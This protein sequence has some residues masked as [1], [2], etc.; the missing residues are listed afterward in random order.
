MI[1]DILA[2]E[3][4][5]RMKTEERSLYLMMKSYQRALEVEGCSRNGWEW[6]HYF[7]T[8]EVNGLKHE[9]LFEGKVLPYTR[10]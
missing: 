4:L 1:D 3:N 2:R 6:R 10:V 5:E 8:F 9:I 7:N